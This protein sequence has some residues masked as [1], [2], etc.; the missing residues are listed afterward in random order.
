[1]EFTHAVSAG[2]HAV[3]QHDF[4]RFKK[5]FE[6][7]RTYVKWFQSVPLLDLPESHPAPIQ[8]APPPAMPDPENN[9]V[10]DLTYMIDLARLELINSQSARQPQALLSFDES[11][12]IAIVDKCDKFL[13]DYVA[14]IQPLDLPESSPQDAL[15]P[16]GHRGTKPSG[17]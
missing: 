15:A 7:L 13:D 8:V 17:T 1:M 14:Q 6:S 3:N 2:I 5:Y 10:Q 11:R 12:F 4:A 9:S 16:H